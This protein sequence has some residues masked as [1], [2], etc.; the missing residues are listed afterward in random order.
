MLD[1]LNK[2]EINKAEIN[3]TELFAR[4][5]PIV[6]DRLMQKRVAIVGAF[7]NA[8]EILLEY[9]VSCGLTKFSYIPS[10]S[11]FSSE[12]NNKL[13]F[14]NALALISKRLGIKVEGQIVE[15][16]Y[17]LSD[18]DLIISSGGHKDFE[19]TKKL[20]KDSGK[21][22]IFY[23]LMANGS[24]LVVFLS[25]N[26]L[27]NLPESVFLTSME[28]NLFNQL[29]LINIVA[30]YAKGLL[31]TG[32]EYAH[33]DIESVVNSNKLLIV[34]HTSWP[35]VV[36]PIGVNALLA[37]VKDAVFDLKEKSTLSMEGKNCLVVGLGS[38]GSVVAKTLSQLGANLILVDGE[39]VDLTNPIRQ[40][41][42]IEQI[43]ESKAEAC[44]NELKK[45]AKD[46]SQQF[47]AYNFSID[48]DKSILELENLLI[49]H[50]IDV[51]VVATGTGNDRI[52]SQT[53]V[54][55]KVPHVVVSC[56]ARARFFEAIVVRSGAPC[57]GCVRGHLYLGKTPSLTPEQKARYVSSEHDLAAEPATRIETG[58][59][60][61]LASHIAYSLL[62]LEKVE[63][64]ARALRNEQ[65]FFLGGNISEKQE[66]KWVYTI[67]IPGEV[68]LFGLEDIVGRGDYI[69][70]WDCSR[71]IPVAI[72]YQIID[73]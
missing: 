63:W 69:E 59:A 38:L 5:I 64:L 23:F 22:G 6:G 51:A 39:N 65:I 7:Q 34:G 19:L 14:Y 35:W 16:K 54:S 68:K 41:Y 49:A 56:Y 62:N 28:S 20:V 37:F 21:E 25:P 3:I 66:D 18:L 26:E 32:T 70:C 53:L 67:E 15:D 11:S 17:K 46:Q 13:S 33:L 4:I 58:R 43:G 31:L 30:N 24:G 57:F 52:I 61:D 44:A 40:V 36:K 71:K 48:T 42:S 73:K 2:A 45:N 72:H 27:I 29:H 1:T 12:N 50:N 55:K 10:F 47:F 9:L 60:A 8:T